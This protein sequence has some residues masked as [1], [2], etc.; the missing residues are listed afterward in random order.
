[1][2]RYIITCFFLSLLILAC[3]T[4]EKDIPPPEIF[5][6]MPEGGF[7]FDVDSV[8]LIEPKITYDIDSEY[9]WIENEITFSTDKILQF[10]NKEHGS[11]LY[12]FKVT[13]PN[14]EH[15]KDIPVHAIDF[16]TFEEKKDSLN[17]DGYLNNHKLGYHP[18]KFVQFEYT[19]NEADNSWSGFAISENTNKSDG[20]EKNEYSVYDS[21]GA[22][23]S[24]VFAV[25]KQSETNHKIIFG[26]NKLH[27]LK[28]IAINNSTRAY[29]VMQ[30]GFKKKEAE[31]YLLLTITGYDLSGNESGTPVEFLLGD[32]RP[33]AT[34]DKYLISTWNDIDLNPLG[35]V[36][37]IGFKL[38]SSRE[39][40]P[41]FEALKYF[42]LD[43]LKIKD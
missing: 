5:I 24:E 7:D 15:A 40:D 4:T 38:T 6:Q 13:T 27:N 23:E 22:D 10:E 9:A 28:S 30:S 14:G 19:F 17:D 42:C 20:S 8:E 3:E 2:Y 16:C 11:Y 33:E 43:N 31:D 29:L 21:N 25:F 37:S 39:D 34:A 35:A 1:M 26:D 41:E 18:F 32:Y 36:H 12:T